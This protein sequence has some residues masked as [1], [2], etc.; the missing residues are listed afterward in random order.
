MKESFK[1][2]NKNLN[3]ISL[4]IFCNSINLYNVV[5]I[6]YYKSITNSFVLG[7]SIFSIVTISSAIFELPTGIL[8]DIVGRKRTIV[9]GSVCSLLSAFILFIANNYFLLIIY[10]IISGIEIAF[11][12]GN[13]DAYVYE[14]LKMINKE[15]D[16]IKFIG[17]VK[18]MKYLAGALSGFLGAILLYFFSYKFIIG[19]S[20]IPKAIQI[21]LSLF[22]GVVNIIKLNN[23]KK[24]EMITKPIKEVLRNKILLKKVLYD[25]IMESTSESCYQFRSA[26][27]ETVWP[28]WAIGIPGI[29]SNIGAFVSNWFSEKIIKITSRKKY[30]IF[31]HFY[32]II[33]NITAVIIKNTISP[34]ILVSNSLF[35]NDF[36]NSEIEQKLYKDEY[37]ASMG[38]IKNFTQ[39]ILFSVF[40]VVLGLI[41]DCFNIITS[42]TIFQLINIIPI[43]ANSKIIEDVEKI[44]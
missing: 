27:Y 13:N 43:I 20:I 31:S 24:T 29:L 44:K 3:L 7:M 18:S 2:C 19:I 39:S 8:S 23:K 32:S 26:F 36:I 1:K 6:L 21:I 15:K 28:I 5:A 10:A 12:S 38:S 14:N 30:W 42:F 22:L 25:G 16:Y 40:S 37:R 9:Y 35:H 17:K 33:S 11:F 41:A 34:I 4:I